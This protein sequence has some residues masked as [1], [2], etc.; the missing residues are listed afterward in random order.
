MA[1]SVEKQ[2]MIKELE[3]SSLFETI[4]AINGNASEDNLFKL[5]KLTVTSNPNVKSLLLFVTDD[6]GDWKCVTSHGSSKDLKEW[7]LP[8]ACLKYTEPSNFDC[9]EGDFSGFDMIIPVLHK[10]QSLA[11]VLIEKEPVPATEEK[12]TVNFIEAL[13]NIIIVAVEN[14][15]FAR[16]EARQREYRKQ[17]EIARN[18]QSFLFPKE[19]PNGDELSVAASY[20]PHHTIGGDYYD[21][22]QIDEDR[23]LMCIADVSGKGIPAAILM[24]NFQGGVRTLVRQESKLDYIV[25]ELNRLIMENAQGENFIT[26]FLMIYDKSSRTLSYVNAGHNPPFLFRGGEFGRLEAGTTIIG[27]FKTLPFL[28]KGIIENIDD[29]FVFC[30]TD[31]FTETY[32]DQ[33]EELGDEQLLKFLEANI[34]LDQQSLHKNMIAHL[35]TFKGH[36]AYADDITLLSCRVKLP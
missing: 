34:H 33:G 5:F 4:D 21:F 27:S 36:Q 26:A 6:Q 1:I 14:K 16:R 13:A 10:Q 3:L 24:S 12:L 20:L 29:F 18:V 17:L 35:N 23:F 30:F 7:R 32:N 8:K 22:I 28:E 25:K 2:L 19:L 15:K 9:E 31:G 11:Y